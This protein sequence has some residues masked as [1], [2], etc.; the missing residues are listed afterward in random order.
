MRCTMEERAYPG[1]APYYLD[2]TP[3]G[4]SRS[5]TTWISCFNVSNMS[6]FPY[7]WAASA[8]ETPWKTASLARIR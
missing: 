1:V 6:V 8:R 2:D 5:N 4:G 7:P 3:C